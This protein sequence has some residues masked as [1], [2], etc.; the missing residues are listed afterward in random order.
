MPPFMKKRKIR[1]NISERRHKEKMARYDKF[2]DLF[3]LSVEHQIG[4]T[5]EEKEKE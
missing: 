2:L 4:K 1:E 5:I 3:Q